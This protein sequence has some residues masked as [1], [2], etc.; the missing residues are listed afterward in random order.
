MPS[1]DTFAANYWHIYCHP[2]DKFL[3]T[4]WHVCCHLMKHSKWL[5]NQIRMVRGSFVD[6]LLMASVGEICGKAIDIP[7]LQI[8]CSEKSTYSLTLAKKTR[9]SRLDDEFCSWGTRFRFRF[10]GNAGWGVDTI[11]EYIEDTSRLF[12]VFNPYIFCEV[13][14]YCEIFRFVEGCFVVSCDG[15]YRDVENWWSGMFRLKFNVSWKGDVS[16]NKKCFPGRE[17]FSRKGTVFL[18]Q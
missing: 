15:S 1:K 16:M 17:V 13:M 9:I 5:L 6:V 18:K 10:L 11:M 12:S 7:L 8:L 2:I 3:A 14:S 4:Y